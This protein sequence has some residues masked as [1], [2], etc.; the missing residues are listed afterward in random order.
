MGETDNFCNNVEH[1]EQQSLV[2]DPVTSARRITGNR[3][4]HTVP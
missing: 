3:E 2:N 4:P 1:R